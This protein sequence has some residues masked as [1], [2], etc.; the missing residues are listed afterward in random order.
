[1]INISYHF[2]FGKSI[3]RNLKKKEGIFMSKI[4]PIKTVIIPEERYYKMVESYDEAV[5]EVRRLKEKVKEL[6]TCIEEGK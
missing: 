6:S 2:Y 1:L 4:E 3:L 5:E